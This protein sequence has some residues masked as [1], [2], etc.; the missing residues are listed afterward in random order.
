MT[1]TLLVVLAAAHFENAYFLA[2][3]MRHY[4]GCYLGT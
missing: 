4:F 1:L 2:A 3:A